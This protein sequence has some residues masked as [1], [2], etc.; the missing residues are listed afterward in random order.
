M[1]KPVKFYGFP[2]EVSLYYQNALF[3]ADLELALEEQLNRLSYLGPLRSRPERL[4]SWS[5]GEPEDVGWQGQSTIQAILAA[6]ERRLNWREKSRRTPFQVVIAQ[7]L[8]RM[9][10]VH[11]FAVVPIAP[12]RDEY[13][14]T[15]RASRRS[16][17]VKL[18]DVGFG[19]S[20]VLPVIV[21]SFYAPSNSTVG[22]MEQP[23]I[24][25]H[26][27]VQ[28]ALGDMMIAAITARED[29]ARLEGSN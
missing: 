6:S 15:V 27:S 20:Q 11:S 4:Y 26:P 23:E 8:Q 14:V 10:L 12:D 21:Q 19:V 24:H 5:T 18:T 28:A 2:Q 16:A 7:W 13:E 29:T 9:G 17:D 3:L 25:L 1:P 22:L